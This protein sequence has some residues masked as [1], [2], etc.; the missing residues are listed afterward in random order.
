MPMPTTRQA[1]LAGVLR[2]VG[3]FSI[4]KFQDR[5]RVQKS[6]YLLQAFG[7]YLGYNFNWYLYGPYSPALARD[8]FEVLPITDRFEP[9]PFFEAAT[10][11]RFA[12]FLKFLGDRKDDPQW[13]ELVGSLHML[14]RLYGE[15]GRETIFKKMAKKQPYLTEAQR[16]AGWQRLRDFELV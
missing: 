2:R 16:I 5:L 14:N 9:Q 13:M 15:K 4:N 1:L 12:S 11:E 8:A 10:E 6:V 3:R 7:I